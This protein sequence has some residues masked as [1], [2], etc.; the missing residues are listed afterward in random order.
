[1]QTRLLEVLACPKCLGKLSCVASEVDSQGDIR[2]GTLTCSHCQKSYPIN[3]SIPRFVEKENYT[4]SFG[5][6][7]NRFK[8][9]QIDSIN[10][11]KLS[12]S[13][14][15]KETD[16]SPEWI[17][18]KWILDAGSGAGRF[19]D[20]VSQN[21]CEVVGVDMSSAVDAAHSTFAGR[22]NVHLVQASIDALPLRSAVFDGCYCIGVI[23]HT[24]DPESCLKALPRVLRPGGRLAVT[25]YERKPW[26]K[27]NAKYLIRPLTKRM[28]QEILFQAIRYLMPIMFAITEVTFRI[29]YLGR[30]F[31]YMIPVANYVSLPELSLRRRYDWALLDTFDMLSPQ[32]DQPQTE[33][34]VTPLLSAEGIEELVRLQ[35]P[36]LNLVGRKGA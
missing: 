28:D 7:W 2:A 13:R 14:F 29:P 21:Q 12:A 9:E 32:Y 27:L 5:L 15:Y 8:S 19:L 16:W 34:V 17:N 3:N 22:R 30:L 24:L 25:I 20:V 26:T 33:R 36:G 31:R 6:Q 18:N 11:T 4:S 1:M 10:G 23:Q 35:N